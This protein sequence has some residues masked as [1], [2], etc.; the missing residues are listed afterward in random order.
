[1][2]EVLSLMCVH[3]HPDDECSSTGGTLAKYSSENVLTSLITA[4][5]GEVGEIRDPHLDMAPWET[6]GMVR[7]RELK[8]A[9][10]VLKVNFVNFLGY[11]DSGMAGTEDNQHI[12]AF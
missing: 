11:R 3:A 2:P 6:L 4:T 5:K 7:Q 8:I 12:D 1:M 10:G 9:T